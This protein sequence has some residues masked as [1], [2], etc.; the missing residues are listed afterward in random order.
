MEDRSGVRLLLEELDRID[1]DL[2]PAPWVADVDGP[3]IWA[4][5]EEREQWTGKFSTG[6]SDPE[7]STAGIT[8]STC[9][10]G[11][12]SATEGRAVARLRNLV[13]DVVKTIRSLDAE[14]IK[15]K[16]RKDE[17]FE[18]RNR[19]VA[20]LAR[21][22]VHYGGAAG[23]AQHVDVPGV[24]W[25]P[26]WR[27]LV[28]IDLP[29]GQASWH[30]HDS[31]AHVFDGLPTY[32]K[33][34]DG[35][36]TPKKYERV[37][38]AFRPFKPSQVDLCAIVGANEPYCREASFQEHEAL[39]VLVRVCQARGD[40][41]QS[42]A[43]AL[44]GTVLREDRAFKNQPLYDLQSRYDFQPDFFGLID[45]GL[46]RWSTP[47]ANRGPLEFTPRG[48]STLAKWVQW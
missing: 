32:T 25:D 45:R 12:G 16:R 19:V 31:H 24:S 26:E 40:E 10:T 37:D 28:T 38:R 5:K 44:M 46:A 2:A 15:Y 22:V 34:W 33:A 8:G 29:T 17:A 18:E 21:M 42:V 7:R 14:I 20:C 39:C 30:A 35:H 47:D 6:S 43:A 36:G 13:S 41:W 23:V 9:V 1:R 4:A 3:D 48:L 27:T 11:V